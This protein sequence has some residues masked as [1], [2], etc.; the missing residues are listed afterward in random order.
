MKDNQSNEPCRTCI[1]LIKQMHMFEREFRDSI[2]MMLPCDECRRRQR[3]TRHDP[4][5]DK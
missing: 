3:T 2:E 4:R 5:N 1:E